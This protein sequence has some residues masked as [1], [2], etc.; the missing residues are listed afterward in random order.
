MS[1]ERSPNIN[2]AVLAVDM[3][4]SLEVRIRGKAGE[5]GMAKVFP[6]LIDEIKDFVNKVDEH[7]DQYFG[8]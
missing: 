8:G 1:V 5:A 7:L 6:L 3:T 2:A 4:N